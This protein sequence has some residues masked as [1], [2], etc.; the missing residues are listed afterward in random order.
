M[1]KTEEEN[2]A[3]KRWER[4]IKFRTRKK[5]AEPGNVIMEI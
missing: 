3:W 4:H 1:D 5:S 2:K